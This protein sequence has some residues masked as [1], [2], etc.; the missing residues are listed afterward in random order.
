MV[1]NLDVVVCSVRVL[2]EPFTDT[3]SV[4]GST[5]RRCRRPLTTEEERTEGCKHGHGQ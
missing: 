3:D 5:D 1:T 2:K 4:N